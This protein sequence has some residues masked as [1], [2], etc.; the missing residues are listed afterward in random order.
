MNPLEIIKH[1]VSTEKALRLMETENKLVFIVNRKS[2]KK[3]IKQAV[4]KM[5][6]V[7]VDQVRTLITPK[8][9]KKAYVKL[10]ADN[11][12]VDITTK[13]GLT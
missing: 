11:P 6:D 9:E 3:M 8:A 1:P 12:A 7:K 13:M 5:F 2:S 10:S 4:E